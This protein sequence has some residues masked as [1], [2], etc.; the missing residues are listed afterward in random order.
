MTDLK[1]YRF[2]IPLPAKQT[3]Q[4]PCSLNFNKI[5]KQVKSGIDVNATDEE[6]KTAITKIIE[7]LEQLD[8][9]RRFTDHYH[10]NHFTYLKS[11]FVKEQYAYFIEDDVGCILTNYSLQIIDYLLAQGADINLFGFE[12]EPFRGGAYTLDDIGI[13]P[14][15]VAIDA[16]MLKLTKAL[17]KRGANPNG[18]PIYIA[19]TTF[20]S[21][22]SM[23]LS[24]SQHVCPEDD[25]LLKVIKILEKHGAEDF[26]G[27]AEII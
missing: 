22:L 23:A 17:L 13:N 9:D 7:V 14:L 25:G 20:E 26:L 2:K 15:K 18:Y 12:K 3:L 8:R 16:R 21:I 1:T 4:I 6:G 27:E 10:P 24:D 5:K 11:T 19:D